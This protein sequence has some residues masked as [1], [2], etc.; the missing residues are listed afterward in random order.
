MTLSLRLIMDN[1]VE[2]LVE[3]FWICRYLTLQKLGFSM[4]EYP[5]TFLCAFPGYHPWGWKQCPYYCCFNF[6]TG[7]VLRH[8]LVLSPC[9][10]F[11]VQ[12]TEAQGGNKLVWGHITS[13]NFHQHLGSIYGSYTLTQV[14][15]CVF[16]GPQEKV[17]RVA[18]CAELKGVQGSGLP[19]MRSRPSLG[20]NLAFPSASPF[21][22]QE[23]RGWCGGNWCTA[24]RHRNHVLLQAWATSSP[25]LR[26]MWSLRTL[27]PTSEGE[28]STPAESCPFA[29]SFYFSWHPLFPRPLLKESAWSVLFCFVC[30]LLH[31]FTETAEERAML[32]SK[33]WVSNGGIT[34]RPVWPWGTSRSMSD[35]SSWGT[36]FS[37][38]WEAFPEAQ[39]DSVSP[40]SLA[41]F[42]LF[43]VMSEQ[44][45]ATNSL[46]SLLKLH[47]YI[48][49]SVCL[50]DRGEEG[51]KRGWERR[52][53]E[54][55]GGEEK[56]G[57]ERREEEGSGREGSGGGGQRW[58]GGERTEGRGRVKHLLC[59][60][61]LPTINH[62][63]RQVLLPIF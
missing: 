53:K 45:L 37:S 46:F 6:K 55:R 27:E 31:F 54:G 1:L 43:I 49:V 28:A 9:H 13:W 59:V 56:G 26:L 50:L 24:T 44:T 61:I 18:R 11:A 35:D 52:R 48:C 39:G 12:E 22:P 10:N 57:E 5:Q 34:I 33:V 29:S 41:S 32:T 15:V 17:H 16:P 60:Q 2:F 58:V 42:I 40:G 20:C 7:R 63:V 30:Q 47:E 4:Q 62:P 25:A 8:Q 14:W 23:I 3:F 19:A 51:E 21:R 36:P 38:S